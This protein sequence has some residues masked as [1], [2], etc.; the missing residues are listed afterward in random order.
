MASAACLDVSLQVFVDMQNCD[1][2][3]LPVL[4]CLLSMRGFGVA[5]SSWMDLSSL[6]W[7]TGICVGGAA[8]ALILTCCMVFCNY[9]RGR[10]GADLCSVASAKKLGACESGESFGWFI[11]CISLVH[12]KNYL[13]HCTVALSVVVTASCEWLNSSGLL[14]LE[15]RGF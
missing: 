2:L 15:R 11:E 3:E 5:H 9:F 10:F 1:G 6:P 7:A 12:L 8:S 13:Q 14:Q 4:I